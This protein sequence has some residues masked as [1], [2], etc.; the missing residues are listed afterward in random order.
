MPVSVIS[1][2][3]MSKPNPS[4]KEYVWK[5]KLTMEGLVALRS[6]AGFPR[7]I[8]ARECVFTTLPPMQVRERFN[9]AKTSKTFT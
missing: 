2:L 4:S 8:R 1:R 5:C 6:G 3:V 9:H 7:R